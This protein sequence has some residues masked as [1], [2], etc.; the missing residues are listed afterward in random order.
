MKKNPSF[1]INNP[2]GIGDVLFSTPLV[3]SLRQRFPGCR[4]MYMCSPRTRG[5][6]AENPCIDSVITYDRDAFKALRR[7]SPAGWVLGMGRHV[8]SLARR[9]FDVVFDCSLNSQY[10]FTELA[11]G[12]PVRV[13]F[14]FKG[15]GRF[16]THKVALPQGYVEK[17]AILHYLD[18]LAPLDIPAATSPYELFLSEDERRRAREF[19]AERSVSGTTR[20]IALCPGGGESWGKDAGYRRWPLERWQELAR[21]L[22]RVPETRIMVFAGPGEESLAEGIANAAPEAILPVSG[23]SLR[24]FFALLALSSFAVCNDGGPLHAAAALGVRTVSMIGPVDERVY[25]PFPPDP[26]RH[27]VLT[28]SLPCRPCYT[29]FRYPACDRKYA[30]IHDISLDRMV[31]AVRSFL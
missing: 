8:W 30:C 20:L 21:R 19:L 26:S 12:I 6:L 25:G 11:A 16:L 31:E 24:E 7:R 22:A 3:K 1:L 27:R 17:H 14:D 18:L 15:R 23:R 4:L 28:A 10:G 9:R 13:G 5:V 29:R 2:Y